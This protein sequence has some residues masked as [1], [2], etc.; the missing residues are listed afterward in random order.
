MKTKELR[1]RVF[2]RMIQRKIYG[3]YLDPQTGEWRK[4]HY[5]ELRDLYNRPDIVNEIVMC[6]GNKKH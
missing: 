6:G 4:R 3:L 5:D 2:K 1:L